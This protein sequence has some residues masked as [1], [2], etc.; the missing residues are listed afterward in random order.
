MRQNIFVQE[1]IR[2]SG[3][4]VMDSAFVAEVLEP[5]TLLA[6]A[7][8]E[9]AEESFSHVL[10]LLTAH[11][12]QRDPR[13]TSPLQPLCQLSLLWPPGGRQV[14]PHVGTTGWKVDAAPEVK[15]LCREFE[16]VV[17]ADAKGE[18][19]TIRKGIEVSTRSREVALWNRLRNLF[20]IDRK[21][22][23]KDKD[24]VRQPT[25][26]FLIA[27]GSGV[28]MLHETAKDVC[29]ETEDCIAY[30]ALGTDLG[31]LWT[32]WVMGGCDELR[33]AAPTIFRTVGGAASTIGIDASRALT[34]FRTKL[35]VGVSLRERTKAFWFLYDVICLT[36]PSDVGR[37]P[38]AG[39]LMTLSHIARVIDPTDADHLVRLWRNRRRFPRPMTK[40]GCGRADRYDAM[41]VLRNAKEHGDLVS[42]TPDQY[43]QAHRR[44]LDMDDDPE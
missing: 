34:E 16:R 2:A 9:A 18:L 12:S 14:T 25:S 39:P 31:F 32:S 10:S 36:P 41:R 26:P 38:P 15:E 6:W 17:A 40:G 33:P 42:L 8:S 28:R 43:L 22:A 20:W 23:C 3:M 7:G 24:G 35:E 5:T 30:R 27:I 13:K 19:A 21:S 11:C 4:L 37:K 29:R 44:L 1:E